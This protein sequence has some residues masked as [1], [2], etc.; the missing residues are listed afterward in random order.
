MADKIHSSIKEILC[1]V[2]LLLKT[3]TFVFLVN[4]LKAK[5]LSR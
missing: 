1:I 5:R 2:I 3:A 4:T